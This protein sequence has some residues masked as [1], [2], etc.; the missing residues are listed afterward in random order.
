MMAAGMVKIRRL[1]HRRYEAGVLMLCLVIIAAFYDY[2]E[3]SFY[4]ISNIWLLAVLA[5][6][7]APGRIRQ[8]SESVLDTVPLSAGMNARN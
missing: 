8:G 5:M 3:A 6:T 1:F 4:A 2:T 7:E